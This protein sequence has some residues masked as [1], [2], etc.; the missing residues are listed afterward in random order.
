VENKTDNTTGTNKI[1][2]ESENAAVRKKMKCDSRFGN[3]GGETSMIPF[4]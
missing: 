4:I 1:Y 2:D 3:L